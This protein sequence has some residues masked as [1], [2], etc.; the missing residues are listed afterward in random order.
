[1]VWNFPKPDSINMRDSI[2]LNLGS[3][4]GVQIFFF[5]ILKE[6]HY[7]PVG[8]VPTVFVLSL[9]AG[10]S[11]MLRLTCLAWFGLGSKESLNVGALGVEFSWF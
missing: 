7:I 11:F 3:R 1:M 10:F 5:I 9:L 8:L 6:L 2:S 4:I